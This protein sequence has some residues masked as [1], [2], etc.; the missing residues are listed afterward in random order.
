MN[1]LLTLKSDGR[2]FLGEHALGF[3]IVK[4]APPDFG[5]PQAWLVLNVLPNGDGAYLF[6]ARSKT[7]ALNIL[8]DIM[9]AVEYVQTGA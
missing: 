7:G 6:A 5:Q 8:Q 9:D 1:A 2:V 3:K 4:D